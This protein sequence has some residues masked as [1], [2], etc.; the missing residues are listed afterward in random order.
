MNVLLP[1]INRMGSPFDLWAGYYRPE[2]VDGQSR[3][4]VVVAQRYV[5]IAAHFY[6]PV[7]RLRYHPFRRFYELAS[8]WRRDVK[9]LSDVDTMCTHPAYQQIIGMGESVLPLI[10]NELR[11]AQ[12]Y[13]FWALKAITAEDPV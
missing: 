5:E 2:F 3:E 13:W 6:Q 9:D 1:T 8:T 7:T 4:S 10:F 11:T 12:D